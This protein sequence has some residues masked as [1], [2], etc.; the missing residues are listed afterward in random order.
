MAGKLGMKR[1]LLSSA[2]WERK[3]PAIT[4]FLA[5]VQ[6]TEGCWIWRG[7]RSGGRDAKT[8]GIFTIGSKVFGNH[9]NIYAHQWSYIHFNGP[10]AEG[11]EIDHLCRNGHCVRPDHLEAVTRRVNILRSSNP[12][13]RNAEK[14]HCAK[15]HAYD[16]DNTYRDAYGYR[17]CRTCGRENK[18]KE[19]ARKRSELCQQN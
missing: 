2:E 9:R 11:L 7:A 18:R 16:H 1:K 19:F 8:Y 4:R 5:K 13:A 17:H 10:I 12:I 6:K 14:S 15:G 3:Y